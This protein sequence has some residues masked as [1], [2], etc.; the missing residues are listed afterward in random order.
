MSTKSKVENGRL[1]VWI[2][3]VR[4]VQSSSMRENQYDLINFEEVEERKERLLEK[5][6]V[7]EDDYYNSHLV[8]QEDL[9]SFDF[10]DYKVCIQKYV[11]DVS[12]I[13]NIENA[14]I[15]LNRLTNSSQVSKRYAQVCADLEDETIFESEKI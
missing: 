9:L 15:Y 7:C 14:F 5:A 13:D 4:Y 3:S 2:E 1:I 12:E 8:E 6:S 11:F 10:A